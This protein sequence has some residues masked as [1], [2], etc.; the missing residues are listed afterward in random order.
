MSRDPKERPTA[1][2][3]MRELDALARIKPAS[4]KIVPKHTLSAACDDAKVPPAPAQPA[5]RGLPLTRIGSGLKK[6]ASLS[7][8]QVQ[9][10]SRKSAAPNSEGAK[11]LGMQG[12]VTV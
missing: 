12:S 8:D 3:V 2:E 10:L 7:K 11:T 6:L 4:A 1:V 9:A 5:G